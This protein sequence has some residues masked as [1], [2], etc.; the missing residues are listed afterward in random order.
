M[1][2][3]FLL[4][5]LMTAVTVWAQMPSVTF[6]KTSKDLN[7]ASM[8]S[9]QVVAE[10]GEGL[11]V[12]VPG[13]RA[14]I[15]GAT[16]TNDH[17]YLRM[18]DRDGKTLRE[19]LLPGTEKNTVFGISLPSPVAATLVDGRAYLA[20]RSHGKLLRTVVDP[21]T[22]EVLS[23]GEVTDVNVGEMIHMT[24]TYS[25]NREYVAM[26]VAS[27][28]SSQ[29]ILLDETL[30][31]LWVKNGG[32]YGWLRPD[33]QG[34]VYVGGTKVDQK[35]THLTLTMHRTDGQIVEEKVDLPQ[36]VDVQFLN[37]DN[38]VMV[39]MGLVA[40][41]EQNKKDRYTT[42]DRIAGFAFDFES[43]QAKVSMDNFTSDELNNFANL[44]TK[45]PNK[46]GK[47]DCLRV[48]RTLATTFGGVAVVDRT[49]QVTTRDMKT[50]ATYTDYYNMGTLVMAVDKEGRILWHVPF[51][52]YTKEG[53]DEQVFSKAQLFEHDGKVFFLHVEPSLAPQ[54]DIAKPASRFDP[55][56]THNKH[57]LYCIDAQG[58]VEKC[59]LKLDGCT[60]GVPFRTSANSYVLFQGRSHG[61]LATVQF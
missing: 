31:P 56:K 40:C 25:P 20:Y 51:R 7:Y 48:H 42:F 6:G 19:V 4:L 55:G 23:S 57:G 44:S 22:M 11:L 34:N 27:T 35:G 5:A 43:R 36:M 60:F 15:L 39:A 61:G 28:N 32:T 53:L 14:M 9:S 50:G 2:K 46:V 1:K 45:K 8:N 33:N 24:R 38:G 16:T 18:M 29:L 47:A 49:W 37:A 13:T 17:I 21:A 30:Q 41:D 10:T 26:E 59:A 12:V 54:Y 3:I 52:N 58:R